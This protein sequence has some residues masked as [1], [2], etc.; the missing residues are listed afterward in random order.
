MQFRFM[1]KRLKIEDLRNL[2]TKS[3]ETNRPGCS[4]KPTV[5]QIIMSLPLVNDQGVQESMN[6]GYSD[7]M[8]AAAVHPEVLHP[9]GHRKPGV[10]CV[11][12][13]DKISALCIES[14]GKALV[15][16][17]KRSINHSLRRFAAVGGRSM[18]GITDQ[19][20]SIVHC[21]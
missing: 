21:H 1:I 18:T 4:Q 14:M 10:S 16:A 17:F 15:L 13:R 9:Y 19:T 2:G 7:A 3:R 20:V 8:Q 5:A 11:F 6:D 12:V